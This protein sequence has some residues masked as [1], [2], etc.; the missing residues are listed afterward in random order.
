MADTIPFSAT[1]KEAVSQFIPLRFDLI[2]HPLFVE[3]SAGSQQLY[4]LL[5]RYTCRAEEGHRLSSYFSQGWLAVEGWQGQWADRLRISKSTVSRRLEEMSHLGIIQYARRASSRSPDDSN[6]IL[7]GRWQEIK[8]L[9]IEA[10]FLDGVLTAQPTVAREQ[11]SSVSAD[12]STVRQSSPRSEF[13]EDW[14]SPIGIREPQSNDEPSPEKRCTDATAGDS[15]AQ[16]QQLLEKRC[17]DATVKAETVAQVQRTNREEEENKEE[18]ENREEETFLSFFPAERGLRQSVQANPYLTAADMEEIKADPDGPRARVGR[19]LARAQQRDPSS[20]ASAVV[21][22][23]C[24]LRNIEQPEGLER[25]RWEREIARHLK[26][27]KCRDVDVA[28]RALDR[29]FLDDEYN[30]YVHK[31]PF[32][33]QFEIDL[34][35]SLR[36]KEAPKRRPLEQGLLFERQK[37]VKRD[38]RE[39]GADGWD[40]WPRVLEALQGRMTRATFEMYLKDTQSALTDGCLTVYTSR[41]EEVVDWLDYRLRRVVEE[42]IENVVGKEMEV[43]V[44]FREEDE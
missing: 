3:W 12:G 42:A 36:R 38:R 11:Q 29:L 35:D 7:L 21:D 2:D 40:R 10:F 44:E 8:G 20:I 18:K 30:W 9:R 23:L 41:G 25:E 24:V 37:A 34:R 17:V 13:T 43:R 14:A 39:S 1:T 32:S 27:A 28:V 15:V 19:A 16:V 22:R 33:K 31:S 4:W 26:A 5:R 6:V